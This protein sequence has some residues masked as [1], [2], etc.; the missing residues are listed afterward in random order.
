MKSGGAD[1]DAWNRTVCNISRLPKYWLAKFLSEVDPSTEP[2]APATLKAIDDHDTSAIPRLLTFCVQLPESTVLP[3]TMRGSKLI[4]W[5]VFQKRTVSVG[6][7]IVDFAKKY[8]N[9]QTGA[10]DWTQGGCYTFQWDEAGNATSVK[11]LGQLEVPVSIP[12]SRDYELVNPWDV[13]SAMICKKPSKILCCEFFTDGSGPHAFIDKKAK[14]LERI[15]EEASSEI[16]VT[17]NDLKREEAAPDEAEFV[18]EH[19]KEERIRRLHEAQS[20]ARESAKRRRRVA[21]T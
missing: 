17:V 6:Q 16:E 9:R 8:V 1:S 3:K 4:C 20:R 19:L 11:Y 2:F 5:K 7:P 18:G 15:A 12:V 13:A 10:I 14:H 21:I